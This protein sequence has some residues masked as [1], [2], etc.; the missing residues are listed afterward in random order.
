MFNRHTILLIASI[1]GLF[2]LILFLQICTPPISDDW[3]Y[4]LDTI[5]EIFPAVIKHY[6]DW[7]P[8]IA[9]TFLTMLYSQC[10]TWLVDIINTI[11]TFL[12]LILILYIAVGKKWLNY[13]NDWKIL[14]L[15]FAILV[16]S[17]PDFSEIFL[18]HCGSASYAVPIV[19]AL[20]FFA[21]TRDY[22]DSLIHGRPSS[23]GYGR[24]SLMSLC[25][26]VAALGTFQLGGVIFLYTG[27]L[28]VSAVRRKQFQWRLGIIPLLMLVCTAVLL[29][30][31]GNA[32]RLII[33]TG[34]AT[35]GMGTWSWTDRFS[36]HF[37]QHIA[38]HIAPSRILLIL[39]SVFLFLYTWRKGW[40]ERT[41]LVMGVAGICSALAVMGSLY[42]S[43]L[44]PAAR[45]FSPA[46]AFFYIFSG[47]ALLSSEKLFA[48]HR[49]L[50]CSAMVLLLGF[51]L[52]PARQLNRLW[53]MRTWWQRT[54]NILE[55]A[56]GSNRDIIIPYC[57]TRHESP[58]LFAYSYMSTALEREGWTFS[59][60]AKAY[61][62]K[63]VKESNVR[64]AY[65]SADAAVSIEL[66]D[67][68]T[69]MEVQ[70]DICSEE[71]QVVLALPHSGGGLRS[72]LGRKIQMLLMHDGPISSTE[73]AE[74]GYETLSV[75]LTQADGKYRGSVR[76]PGKGEFRKP[77]YPAIYI[78]NDASLQ[79]SFTPLRA[80]TAW[81]D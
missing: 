55:S 59:D 34:S 65:C 38:I 25:A 35:G 27:F 80:K 73:L 56:R 42:I 72:L 18:W 69:S 66:T 8:R 45:A 71:P 14:P 28:C 2:L 39:G 33:A 6:S 40:M 67:V 36:A 61:G 64:C 62:L 29:I 44:L 53:D 37:C 81:A 4:R 58:F 47:V 23:I 52:L 68:E 15:S 51:L 20:A 76:L 21:L 75:N 54:E 31:P 78:G 74:L 57:P 11:I 32:N 19:S 13:V 63:S 79:A 1:L 49:I 70:L 12:F 10:P 26:A 41:N 7:N 60:I 22:L 50:R 77:N 48:T 30:S 17:M 3:A 24:L 16:F 5:S 9:G 46:Y 43:P